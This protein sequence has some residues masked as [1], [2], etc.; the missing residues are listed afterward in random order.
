MNHLPGYLASHAEL[1]A[2]FKTKQDQAGARFL[3]WCFLYKE[4]PYRFSKIYN[5]TK[6]VF[7]SYFSTIADFSEKNCA[8]YC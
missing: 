8:T 1:K 2:T 5:N 3:G 7:K 6:T 4:S